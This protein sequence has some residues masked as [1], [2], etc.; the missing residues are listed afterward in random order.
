VPDPTIDLRSDTVTRPTPAMYEAMMRAPLGDDVFGDDPTVIRLQERV[1]ELLGKEAALFVPSGTMGN[2]VCIR[3]QTE[4]GDEIVAES[5]SHFYYYEGG[6]PAALSGV[7]TRFVESERGVF[8]GAAVQAMLRPRDQHFAPT[9]LVV[10][11]NTHNAGGGKVWPCESIADVARVCRE[12]GLRLHVDGARLMNAAVALGAEPR[13]LVNEADTVSMCFSKGLGAPVGSAVAGSRETIARAHRFRKIF[14]GAMRQAGILAAA[15]LYALEHHVARLAEDHAHARRFAEIVAG[16]PVLR[17]NP[18]DIETNLVY[19][20]V[21]ENVVRADELCARVRA[22]GVWI[23][24]LGT[25]SCR[26]VTHLDVTGEQV[27][28]AARM[29]VEEAGRVR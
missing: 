12:H 23:L 15:C 25:R 3:A 18:A 7:Q 1:A 14:G 24:P 21:D 5:H 27:E 8:T 28:R 22:R 13:A 29:I 6:A 16:S 19:F 17:I 20:G 26:A 11:E 4:P 9:R 2:E 10:I